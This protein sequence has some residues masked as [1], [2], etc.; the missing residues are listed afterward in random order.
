MGGLQ[1]CLAIP[2]PGFNC[3]KVTLAPTRSGTL[4]WEVRAGEPPP[5][6]NLSDYWDFGTNSEYPA[7]KVDFNGDGTATWQEFGDQRGDAPVT[8]SEPVVDN[9]VAIMT[10]PVVSG[11]WSSGCLSHSRPGS[12]ARFYTFTVTEPSEVTI[13]LESGV[14]GTYLYLLRGAGRTGELLEDYGSGRSSAQIGHTLGAGI[15]TVEVTT[16]ESVQTGSFTLTVNRMATPPPPPD[17]PVPTT[18]ATPP[19]PPPPPTPMSTNVPT[20]TPMPP[21]PTNAPAPTATATPGA[22]TRPRS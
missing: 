9:C 2:P 18:T 13:D 15:Y 12:Y 1:T 20:E 8:A 7:L 6:Y 10:G 19:P 17:T 5:H 22:G 16:Y 3:L 14:P 4:P 11:A 21:Q